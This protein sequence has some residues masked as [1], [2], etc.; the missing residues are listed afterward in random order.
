M[1]FMVDFI[2]PCSTLSVAAYQ[3]SIKRL[4]EAIRLKRSR[5]LTKG[6]HSFP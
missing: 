1:G 4:K 3:E 5:L 2:P 6:F